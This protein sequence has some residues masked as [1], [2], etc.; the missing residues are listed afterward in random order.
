M[1]KIFRNKRNTI[2]GFLKHIRRLG[3]NPRTIID[4]GAANG[5]FDL[6]D[7]FPGSHHL[8]I[9]PL[10]EF[11][12]RLE[13]LTKSM[14]NAELIIAAATK[15]SG[16]ITINVHPDLVGSSLYLEDENSDVNGVPRTVQGITL[17]EICQEKELKSPYLVKI[18]VQGAELDVLE[19]AQRT[20]KET[21]VIVMEIS[22]FQ[23]FANGPQFFDVVNYMN[24]QDFVVYDIFDNQYRLLDGAMSQVDLAFVK[25]NGRFRKHH[26]YATPEQRAA[27]NKKLR[28]VL[29]KNTR[30]KQ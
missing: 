18:D 12:L 16:A 30:K 4:V 3:Y 11:Q 20:L 8:L 15:K 10:V 19:G 17:D 9:E 14:I 26:Y 6:Y 21:D 1:R 5:T 13:K 27:Q 7:I 25:K 24:E 23:F 28:K 22:L 2:S 29:G